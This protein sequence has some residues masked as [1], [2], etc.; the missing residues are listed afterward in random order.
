MKKEFDWTKLH[1]KIHYC[2]RSDP[3]CAEI[4]KKKQTVK[5]SFFFKAMDPKSRGS[6]HSSNDISRI[7]AA[8]GVISALELDCPKRLSFEVNDKR[9]DSY[10]GE[11]TMNYKPQ[12]KKE[13]NSIARYLMTI[14]QDGGDMP[15][16][17]STFFCYD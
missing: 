4:N 11:I 12:T 6:I 3:Q 5:Y 9:D 15:K 17:N 14:P 1:K 16:K 2:T 7:I 10:S 13:F 8:H